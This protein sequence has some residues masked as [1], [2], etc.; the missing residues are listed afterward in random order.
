MCASRIVSVDGSESLM[1]RI[2]LDQN[3][4][5]VALKLKAH[6][7]RS[8]KIYSVFVTAVADDRWRI[9]DLFSSL[10][11]SFLATNNVD[12]LCSL[13]VSDCSLS[14]FLSIINACLAQG[15]TPLPGKWRDRQHKS[16]TS[17]V[18]QIQLPSG[19]WSIAFPDEALDM[20]FTS[21]VSSA[22]V[23]LDELS[24]QGTVD[25]ESM[26]LLQPD[27]AKLN[28]RRSITHVDTLASHYT[29]SDL[30]TYSS[31][32]DLFFALAAP[33]TTE[34]GLC[35]VLSPRGE[36]FVNRVFDH[37]RSCKPSSGEDEERC[38]LTL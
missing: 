35:V 20:A 19:D 31:P 15:D 4:R 16:T 32:M 1:Q 2:Q 27:G 26:K 24:T 38:E 11:R 30:F 22:D 10:N 3:I 25:F 23:E 37:I 18:W 7:V 28:V 8:I 29:F 33:L 17:Y 12:A 5:A 9:K 14:S 6:D 36:D 34:Q 21:G 13:A